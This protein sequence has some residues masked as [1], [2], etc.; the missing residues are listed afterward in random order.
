MAPIG[1]LAKPVFAANWKMHH[2]PTATR[3]FVAGFKA[4]VAARPDRSILFFPP[5][6]SLEAFRQAAA[7]RPDLRL[8]I[9]DVHYEDEGAFTGAVSAPMAKDGGAQF[10][11]VGHSER[12][13][14]FG[15]TDVT[16][17]RKLKAALRHGLGPLLCVGETL[18][19]REDGRAEEAVAAQLH[20]ALGDLEP[21]SLEAIMIAYE[22]VW[23][24]GTGRHA[25]P[26]DAAAMHRFVRA[27]IAGRAGERRA[28]EMRVLYGGSVTPENIRELRAQR[29]IDGVLVGGASLQVESFA[30]ICL[31]G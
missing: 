5:A 17:A 9:Q 21:S 11:I 23:A 6:V 27:W 20:A 8:G 1:A 29:E 14:L 25:R 28:R 10:V 31:A 7:D 18:E 2:G 24:I 4:R 26:E 22:P 13:Q 19:Q 3:R 30:S 12:R 16:V 15:D